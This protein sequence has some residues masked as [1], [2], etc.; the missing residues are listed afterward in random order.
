LETSSQA[1]YWIRNLSGISAVIFL[2]IAAKTARFTQP[3]IAKIQSD[4]SYVP[5]LVHRFG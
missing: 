2:Q 4:R 5:E 3:K 1:V